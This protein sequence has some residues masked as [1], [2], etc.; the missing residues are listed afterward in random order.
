MTTMAESSHRDTPAP[1][2]VYEFRLRGWLDPLVMANLFP[3]M[4]LR[5]EK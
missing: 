1:P 3:G 2:L 5:H 4:A